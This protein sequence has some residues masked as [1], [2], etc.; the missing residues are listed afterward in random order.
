MTT[1]FASLQFFCFFPGNTFGP[2]IHFYILA[3]ILGWV[4]HSV[5]L[6]DEGI[7]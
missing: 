4:G 2:A 1:F 5:N 3:Q 7:K 6:S